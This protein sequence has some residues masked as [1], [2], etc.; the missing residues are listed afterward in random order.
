MP[1]VPSVAWAALWLRYRAPVKDCG[2]LGPVGQPAVAF[3]IAAALLSS[4]RSPSC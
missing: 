1:Q 4:P 2:R 3:V